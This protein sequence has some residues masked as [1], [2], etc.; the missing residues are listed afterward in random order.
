VNGLDSGF[1]PIVV[2]RPHKFVANVPNINVG[3]PGDIMDTRRLYDD[4]AL[5]EQDQCFANEPLE[6]GETDDEDEER[7]QPFN[8]DVA[9]PWQ[10][11]G[12]FWTDAWYFVGPG[13][14]VS[15]AY[16]DPGNYQ[17]DITAGGTTR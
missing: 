14:L 7:E 13:W 3:Y 12:S 17:A 6:I 1:C 5:V 8:S 15:I 9:L 16:V 10:P 2:F 4:L 11:S